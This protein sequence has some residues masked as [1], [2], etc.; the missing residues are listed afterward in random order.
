MQSDP[1]NDSR[2]GVFVP[3]LVLVLAVVTWFGFQATQLVA[4][5][6]NL[7]ALSASQ[8]AV[9]R[10]AQQMR[11]QLD[12]I[13][14]GTARLAAQGNQSAQAIVDALRARRITVNPNPASPPQQKN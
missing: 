11:Q 3:V 1:P 5:R 6:K 4:E 14:A 2:H 13:A 10:K 9:Y 12:A 7:V 8:D